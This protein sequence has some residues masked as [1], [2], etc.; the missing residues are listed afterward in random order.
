[1]AEDTLMA[2]LRQGVGAHGYLLIGEALAARAFFEELGRGLAIHPSD[3]V[4]IAGETLSLG[5]VRQFITRLFVKPFASTH[6]LALIEGDLHEESQAALL[7]IIE[8]PPGATLIFCSVRHRDD[9]GATLRSRLET[10][11]LE[12]AAPTAAG[13]WPTLAQIAAMPLTGKLKFAAEVAAQGH[14]KPLTIT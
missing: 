2:R 6:T 8:E 5:E 1:M 14:I 3:I 11:R 13:R 7:K 4:M 9:I 12:G 10:I